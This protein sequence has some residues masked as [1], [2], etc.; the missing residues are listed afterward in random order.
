[1]EKDANSLNLLPLGMILRR[2]LKRVKTIQGD[3]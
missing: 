1:M 2:F 3:A